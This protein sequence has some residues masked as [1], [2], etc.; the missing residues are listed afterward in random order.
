MRNS[1]FDILFSPSEKRHLI[2]GDG[3]IVIGIWVVVSLILGASSAILGVLAG[4][5]L[6]W[7]IWFFRDP[8]RVVPKGDTNWVAPCDGR[9]ISIRETDM[10]LV[11]NTKAKCVSIFMNVFDVHVV[12]TPVA[13]TVEEIDYHVGSFFN[14]SLDKAAEENEN[15]TFL[16]KTADG[17]QMAFRLIA[18]LVARRIVCPYVDEDDALEKGQRVGLIRF[19]S[20]VD[21]FLPADADVQLELGQTTTSGE[22]VMAHV[23]KK[24]VTKATPKKVVAKKKP[25]AK[26]APAQKKPA[27]KKKPTAK[28]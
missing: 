25:A 22:T 1:P 28:K 6:A 18:G 10:P 4:A 15:Q 20:R 24:A 13:G 3:H 14:A 19:G 11:P 8:E 12:R 9:V 2:A 17:Q 7:M 23:K 5:V 21:V 26:K 27:A 16:M